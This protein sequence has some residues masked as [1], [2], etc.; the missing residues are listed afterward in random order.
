MDLRN[1]DIP[2]DFAGFMAPWLVA[3]GSSST[4]LPSTSSTDTSPLN[5]K[6]ESSGVSWTLV[7]WF[8][9]PMTPVTSAY[10]GPDL[11]EAFDLDINR[12]AYAAALFFPPD[13]N[14]QEVFSQKCGLG[15]VF[16][17]LI[18]AIPFS[19]LIFVGIKSIGK[20]KE[21]PSSNY[22]KGLQMQLYKALIAQTVIPVFL[23]FAPFGVL[24]ICPIFEIDCKFLAT[25]LTF[26]YA[27]Y[28]VVDPLPILFFVQNYRNTLTEFFYCCK[29]PK[30]S[31]RVH[32]M[33]EEISRDAE[34]N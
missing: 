18:M 15:L 31:S 23:L 29:C 11:A 28:P 24:F 22:G 34:S 14:G 6:D 7:S 16:Y 25:I 30:Q 1:R 2:M 33:P 9:F 19:I 26:V 5:D 13:P 21:F 12:S 32:I 17:L 8:L 27:V 4:A 10:I 3:L 20:I